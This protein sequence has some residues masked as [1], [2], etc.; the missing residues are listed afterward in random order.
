MQVSLSARGELFSAAATA[1]SNAVSIQAVPDY[2][3]PT[4]LDNDLG[5]VINWDHQPKQRREADDDNADENVNGRKRRLRRRADDI[6]NEPFIE[7]KYEVQVTGVLNEALGDIS[8]A[9][10]RY[11]AE[12][13]E[14]DNE[15]EY[16]DI[17]RNSCAEK[18]NGELSRATS[19]CE[20]AH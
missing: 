17:L 2:P 9:Q 13:G 15:H 1:A 18:W 3:D 12:V 16:L 20:A 5:T 11:Y 14:Y 6:Q 7:I 10:R 19:Q 4:T 8:S